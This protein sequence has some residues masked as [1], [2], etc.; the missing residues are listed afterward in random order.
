MQI[1]KNIIVKGSKGLP[2]SLDIFYKRTGKAKPIIVFSHGFKG[3]KDWGHYDLV[4]RAFAEQGF[5][6]VKFNFSHNGTTPQHLIDF[7]DLEAFGNNNYSIEMDDLGRVLDYI[8]EKQP[9]LLDK[10]LD[11][12]QLFL[13]GHSRGGGITLLKGVEDVRVTGIITWG[14]VLTF[15]KFMAGIPL[16]A[17]KAENVF[18]TI[19]ARTDQKMPL[20]YQLY[21]DYIGNY[22]RLDMKQAAKNIQKPWLI[23][24][25]QED[26]VVLPTDAEELHRWQP[27]SQLVFI[28]AGDHTFGG[29]HPWT[30]DVLPEPCAAAITATIAFIQSTIQV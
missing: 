7:V 13:I 21:E 18:F 29:S 17:W 6:F 8:L 12:Q 16:E 15:D 26:D 24:H 30:A 3:F 22:A 10:E 11:K 4:A 2:I 20:Y 5:V 23:L 9:Y 25:G 1:H 28:A 14:S 27:H 19:N